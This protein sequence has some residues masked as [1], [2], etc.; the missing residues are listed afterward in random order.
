[1]HS[2]QGDLDPVRFPTIF[3]EVGEIFDGFLTI[4][5]RHLRLTDF[6]LVHF[7]QYVPLSRLPL[8]HRFSDP[9]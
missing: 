5:C 1:M 4:F 3:S 7:I 8:F 6:A 9:L 2:Y